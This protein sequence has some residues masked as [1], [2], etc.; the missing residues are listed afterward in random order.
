MTSG[1]VIIHL[2]VPGAISQEMAIQ[3]LTAEEVDRASRFRF[4]KDATNWI[5]CRAQLRMTLGKE[6]NLSPNQVPLVQ[7]EFGK[8]LL[9]PAYEGLHFNLTHSTELALIAVCP[10]GPVGIDLEKNSRGAELLGCESTFCHPQEIEKLPSDPQL[11]ATQLLQLWTN[12]EAVL[13][14]LG[15]GLSYPPEQLRIL[16]DLPIRQAI[17]EPPLPGIADQWLR[18]L[19]HPLLVDY[20]AVVSIPTAATSMDIARFDRPFTI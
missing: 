10:D 17:S 11:R 1:Q 4:S 16:F 6:I 7:S 13:K 2:I 18:N 12:K 8:P 5:S 9:A 3:C 15:T 14:A 19:N 20:Q